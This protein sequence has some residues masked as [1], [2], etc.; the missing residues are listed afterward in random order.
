MFDL[1]WPELLVIIVV[2]VLVIGPR[3]L[4]GIMQALGRF[5]RR[6]QYM[7]FAL[8]KQFEDF[9]EESE[10][11]G[12]RENAQHSVMDEIDDEGDVGEE[13]LTTE[14]DRDKQ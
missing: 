2:A 14:I 8:S 5:V 10:L 11:N 3:E 12:L 9:M 6:L 1:G 4:P 13:L 7:K